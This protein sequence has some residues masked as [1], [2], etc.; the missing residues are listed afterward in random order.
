MS[1]NSILPVQCVKVLEPRCSVGWSSEFYCVVGGQLLTYKKEAANTA[2]TSN[3]SWTVTTP[4]KNVLL[5]RLFYMYSLLGIQFQQVGGAACVNPT[6]IVDAINQGVIGL[7][8]FPV[9]AMASNASLDLGG[10]QAS[11]TD[12]ARMLPVFMQYLHDTANYFKIETGCPTD[13]FDYQ[14]F[15]KSVNEASVCARNIFKPYNGQTQLTSEGNSILSYLTQVVSSAYQSITNNQFVSVRSLEPVILLPPLSNGVRNG[16]EQSLF[17][18]NQFTLSYSLNF[19]KR[20]L[21]S[22]T[23][24]PSDAALLEGNFTGFKSVFGNA[25]ELPLLYCMFITPQEKCIPPAPYSSQDGINYP[26]YQY[27]YQTSSSV[28]PINAG[29]ASIPLSINSFTAKNVPKLLYV[30]ARQAYASYNESAY[31]DSFARLESV[32]IG[33]NNNTSRM[34]EMD[35]QTLFITAQ[36][37]GSNCTYP[38]WVGAAS[39]L[40]NALTTVGQP[41]NGG[42]GVLCIAVT[43]DLGLSADLTESVVGNF[44]I[45][46]NMS[47]SN[48]SGRA[49]ISYEPFCVIVYSGI[50]TYVKSSGTWVNQIGVLS[51]QMTKDLPV[52]PAG[53]YQYLTRMRSGG[54][55]FADKF[56]NFIPKILPFISKVARDPVAHAIGAKALDYVKGYMGS[57]KGKGRRHRRG[58]AAGGQSDSDDGMYYGGRIINKNELLSDSDL[59]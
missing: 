21:C 17:G 54:A 30:G 10:T 48:P 3:L 23:Q 51:D 5:Q 6:E 37:N 9:S 19:Q 2:T 28:T 45:S 44:Q 15:F 12:M 52:A 49:N 50:L 1:T 20:I 42:G 27:E 47:V 31:C 33:W 34:S 22:N 14:T 41:D 55:S 35:T 40:A 39:F 13:M 18:I 32:Q 43:E 57:R 56:Q 7:R 26:L 25:I 11:K 58:G 36:K 24:L 38:K 53:T 46:V 4:S 16:I 59:Y 8:A 29:V